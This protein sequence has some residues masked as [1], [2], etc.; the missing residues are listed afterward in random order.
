MTGTVLRLLTLASM[1]I[2][3]MVRPPAYEYCFQ[4]RH[5]FKKFQLKKC[6]NGSHC[7]KKK[8]KVLKSILECVLILVE[9]NLNLENSN[10]LF[11]KTILKLIC[12]S[13]I[14]AKQSKFS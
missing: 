4:S 5:R 14:N 1:R 11:P 13:Y 3:S 9:K 12:N 6:V 7:K 2:I 10:L 8:K